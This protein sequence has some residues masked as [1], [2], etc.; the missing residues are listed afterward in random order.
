MGGPTVGVEVVGVEVEVRAVVE[1]DDVTDAGTGGVELVAGSTGFVT[2]VL[3][4]AAVVVVVV[5][6]WTGSYCT[7]TAP[8]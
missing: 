4:V 2:E 7:I 1:V 5:G 6:I 8:S 3:L